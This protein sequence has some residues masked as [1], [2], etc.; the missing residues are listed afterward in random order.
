MATNP[1]TDPELAARLVDRIDEAATAV[2]RQTTDRVV[3]LIRAIVFGLLAA[4]GAIGV[5]VLLLI[6]VPRAVQSALDALVDHPQSVWI[7]YFLLSGIFLLF[8]VVAMRGRHR[9][10]D[11]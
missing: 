10:E 11:Q 9:K 5:L 8:G 3:K 2:R 1:I 7:S 6:A 4:L